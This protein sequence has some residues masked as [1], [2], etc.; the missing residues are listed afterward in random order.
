[1]TIEYEEFLTAVA[2]RGD[3]ATR[4][5]AEQV[6]LRVLDTLGQVLSHPDATAVAKNL[7]DP[8]GD[9]LVQA[10]D[11]PPHLVDAEEF[12]IRV[13]RRLPG[14]STETAR[15]DA[16]AVLSTVAECLDPESVTDLIGQLGDDYDVLFGQS[17]LA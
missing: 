17:G 15:W 11:S 1:M 8:L 12:L 14:A 13:A 9:V 2:E 7:P 10:N 5:E 6:S 4:A 3:Y 16:G